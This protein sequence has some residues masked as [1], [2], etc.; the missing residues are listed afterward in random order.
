MSSENILPLSCPWVLVHNVCI[1]FVD[2]GMGGVGAGGE[3]L[4]IAAKSVA[5][6][7]ETGRLAVGG[8]VAAP[9]IPRSAGCCVNTGRICALWMR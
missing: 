9:I 4:L 7:P 3:E 1:R 8:T 2:L 6:M 5:T